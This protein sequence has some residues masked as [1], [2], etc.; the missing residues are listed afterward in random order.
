MQPFKRGEHVEVFYRMGMDEGCYFPVITPSAGQLRPR[1]GRSDGW[2]DARVED[3]WPPVADGSGNAP[4]PQLQYNRVRVRHTHPHWSNKRGERLDPFSDRDMVVFMLPSDVRRPLPSYVPALSVVSVRWGG[5]QTPFNNDQWGQASSSVSD[6]YAEH[7]L[8]RTLYSRLG[9]DYEVVTVFVESGAD[10]RKLQ[11]SAIAPILRGRHLCALYFLWPVM[12]QDGDVEQSGMVNQADYFATV[13]AF[14][15]SGVPTRFPHASHLYE[16][17]L[18]KDWQPSLCLQAK[19]RIPPCVTINR[20]AIVRSPRRAAATVLDALNAC[21]AMRYAGEGG[22]PG[23][24]A[25]LEGETRRGVVKLGFAWEAAHVRVFRGELQLAEALQG[26]ISTPGV[27]ST[28]VLV[29]D[30]VRNHME[31]RCFVVDGAVSHIIYSSFERIYPDGYPRDFVKKERADAIRDWLAGDAA[32]MEDAE[33][34]AGRLVRH[35]L[36]WLRCRSAEATPAIRMDILISRSGVGKADVHTL[37]L[38]EMGFSMLAWPE[39]P[40]I[41]FNALVESFFADMEHTAADAEKLAATRPLGG[42]ADLLGG[43]LS[44]KDGAGSGG[45]PAGVDK[46]GGDKGGDK[47]GRKKKK[48]K[49]GGGGSWGGARDSGSGGERDG[50]AHGHAGNGGGHDGNGHAPHS[51]ASTA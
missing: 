32:A 24:V 9:P 34:K 38:T 30:F 15:A 28:A 13:R 40:H 50:N 42:K 36:G 22:E 3:D 35:W 4:P 11:P 23:C 2:I 33:K 19:L 41:V 47:G 37:E 16:T 1:Y 27:E 29:Q 46:G 8:D 10:L 17:L 39:G 5:E 7:V 31:I 26:L 44:V 20:A 51:G 21:R 45:A 43:M 6:E 14:E 25:P 12:A 48:Q 49:K 18:S